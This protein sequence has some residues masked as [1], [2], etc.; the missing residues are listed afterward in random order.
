MTA[1]FCVACIHTC[2]HVSLKFCQKYSV[3]QLHCSQTWHFVNLHIDLNG[4]RPHQKKHILKDS[5]NIMFKNKNTLILRKNSLVKNNVL[6]RLRVC[7]IQS[8]SHQHLWHVGGK[9]L[10]QHTVSKLPLAQW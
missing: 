10:Y 4:T 6:T 5:Y 1:I 7:R 3:W 9:Q 2:H 8:R